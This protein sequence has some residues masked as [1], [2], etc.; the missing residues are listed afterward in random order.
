MRSARWLETLSTHIRSGLGRSRRG[1]G[2]AWAVWDQSQ[3]T[4]Y[5]VLMWTDDLKGADAQAWL[6]HA[7]Q[8]LGV[9]HHA[10]NHATAADPARRATKK[11]AK[12]RP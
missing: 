8:V 12:P 7:A 5:G 6:A 2:F 3:S 11:A 1:V 10:D 4:E 9:S